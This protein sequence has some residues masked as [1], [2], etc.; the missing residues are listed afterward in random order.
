MKAVFAKDIYETDVLRI[1]VMP[2]VGQQKVKQLALCCS[3]TKST[4]PAKNSDA[5]SPS[6]L[7]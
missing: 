3:S 4:L 6:S 2:V 7:S 5:R 1:Q